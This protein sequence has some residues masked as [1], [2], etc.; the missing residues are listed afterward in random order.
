MRHTSFIILHN[1]FEKDSN[2]EYFT[3]KDPVYHLCFY[4]FPFQHA[5]AK[6]GTQ[7]QNMSCIAGKDRNLVPSSRAWGDYFNYHVVD[8]IDDAHLSVV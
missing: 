1:S 5:L 4:R 7:N 2:N 6:Y 8:E 3:C